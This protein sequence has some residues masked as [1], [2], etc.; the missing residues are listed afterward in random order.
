MFFRP[1]PRDQFLSSVFVVVVVV[2]VI[3]RRDGRKTN[4]ETCIKKKK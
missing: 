2:V 1:H 3:I 4:R